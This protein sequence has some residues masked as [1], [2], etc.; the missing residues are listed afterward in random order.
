MIEISTKPHALVTG[1]TRGIG[2][3]IV[4]R[5]A[6]D[7]FAV[8]FTGRTSKSANAALAGFKA[9]GI[10]NITAIGCELSDLN[11]I[12][13]LVEKVREHATL[14]AL[15]NN[16]GAVESAS[17]AAT[18]HQ[19][20]QR[21][22]ALNVTAAFELSRQ[23]LPL[24]EAKKFGRIIN[25]ASTAGLRGYPYVSAY[26]AAKHALVGLTK[27]LAI[28]VVRKG[29]TVNAVCPSFT[30]T[31]FLSNSI[32]HA[33]KNS[34]KT[35]SVIRDAYQAGIPLGRFITPD[36]VASAVAWLVQP[37]QAAITGQALVI[38]GGELV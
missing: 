38:A 1:G 31:D 33:A 2:A 12:S 5:L 26:C 13:L 14:T 35:E 25:I 16:A 17:L 9:E 4:R 32:T 7:G 36:E 8:T 23:L 27:S 30:D 6:K 34:K 19:L 18:S 21:T 22:F 20:W 29:V 10:S 28:E 11:A 15:V 3:A 37:E 24:F